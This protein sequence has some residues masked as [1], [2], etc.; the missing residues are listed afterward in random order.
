MRKLLSLLLLTVLGFTTSVFAQPSM[1]LTGTYVPRFLSFD[2][3]F[4]NL[5]NRW[6]MVGASVAIV[7]RGQLVYARGFGYANRD[8]RAPVQPNSL[9]RIASVSK[10][11]TATTIL[12]LVEHKQLKLSDSIYRV[13]N[14]T[15][16]PGRQ[17]NPQVYN[18]T[19]ADMLYMTSGWG[20]WFDPMF[21]PWPREYVKALNGMTLPVTCE[22]AARFMMSQPVAYEPGTTFRY[23]N[24]NYCMLGL[25]VEKVTGQPYEQYVLKHILNPIG[26][27]DMRLANTLRGQQAPNEVQYYPQNPPPVQP[28]QEL[29]PIPGLPYGTNQLLYKNFANGGWIASA[30][31][32]AKW[33]SALEE[34]RIIAPQYVNLMMTPPPQHRITWANAREKGYWPYGMGWF[35]TRGGLVRFWYTHGS[36]TGTN[37]IVFR[38]T[39]GT[40]MAVIFNKKPPD[41]WLVQDLRGQIKRLLLTY[42]S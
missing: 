17:V 14:L 25:V 26:I 33:A 5:M 28:T 6:G 36:F 29:I 7:Q 21:G 15:P 34:G 10:A 9:F 11:I 30:T 1:P 38:R 22:T 19:I 41:Y 27:T 37:A 35:L 13:L 16:I 24:L 12:Y 23:S 20:R 3:Q 4:M 2:I 39:D 32:L 8:T 31:D 42:V 18:I 40:I